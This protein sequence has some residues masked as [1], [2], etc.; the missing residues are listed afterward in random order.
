VNL[1]DE[2]YSFYQKMKDSYN[3]HLSDSIQENS[4][5]YLKKID[6]NIAGESSVH[7]EAVLMNV[8]PIYYQFSNKR[9]DHYGY[10][11]NHLVTDVFDNT[12]E[13][14]NFLNKINN[15][16]QNIRYRVKYYIATV[17]T[18]FDGKSTELAKNLISAM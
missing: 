7:L 14:V 11:K 18:E 4:F 10:L 17:D 2:R 5:E 12:N 15:N 6:V 13:L 1:I 3:V 9:F 8:Y 16:K